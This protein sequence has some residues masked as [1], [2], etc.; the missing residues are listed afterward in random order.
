MIFR[1]GCHG[2]FLRVLFHGHAPEETAMPRHTARLAARFARAAAAAILLAALLLCGSPAG[3]AD[4]ALSGVEISGVALSGIE[5]PEVENIDDGLPLRLAVID[6]APYGFMAGGEPAGLGCELGLAL[7]AGAGGRA[8]TTLRSR[9]DAL[10]A[11][12]RGEADMAVMPGG[13]ATDRAVANAGALLESRHAVVGRVATPLRSQDDLPGKTVAV[14]RGEPR[15]PLLATRHG[16]A[17]LPV[18]DLARAL[19][20]LL[21]GRVD[22]VAGERLALL[23]AADAMHLPARTLGQPLLLS[24]VSIDLLVPAAL[25]PETARRLSKA[26]RRLG[27]LGT[28]RTIAARYGL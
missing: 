16:V 6:T 4:T 11:L 19:K 12:A 26:A 25:P 8:E 3:A 17:L 23:H 9:A 27:E 22:G 10:R 5:Q 7:A 2:P 15:D 14:V 20:L 28:F 21:A 18:P 13:P 24:P 1:P